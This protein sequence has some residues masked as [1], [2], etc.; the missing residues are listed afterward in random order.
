MQTM[1]VFPGDAASSGAI[2]LPTPFSIRS[3]EC[4]NERT[5]T[6]TLN[7]SLNAMPGQFVMAWLPRF[8]EK[9]FSLVAADPVT[10]MV[11]AIRQS[12]SPAP[13]QD[14]SRLRRRRLRGRPPP[15]AGK[16]LV[17]RIE[18]A[19]RNHRRPRRRRTPLR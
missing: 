5:R 4:D 3:V 7:A 15:L 16:G 17:T 1:S 19:H 9:P 11:T 14:Q 12:L 6:F 2:H 10:L 18:R 13:P 8:D